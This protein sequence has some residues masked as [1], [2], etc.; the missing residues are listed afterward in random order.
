MPNEFIRHRAQQKKA[1]TGLPCVLMDDG[2]IPF[3]LWRGGTGGPAE[4]DQAERLDAFGEAQDVLK[5]A[6][7]FGDGVN[8]RPDCAESERMDRE[9]EVL[10]R[11]GGILDPVF[12]RLAGERLVQYA[13]DCDGNGGRGGHFRIGQAGAELFELCA[14]ADD[15]ECP[16]P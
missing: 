5:D 4:R 6:D 16:R 14:V 7:A 8:A 12:A 1:E 10:G 2:G 15:D 9:Q 3:V 13:A 11:G